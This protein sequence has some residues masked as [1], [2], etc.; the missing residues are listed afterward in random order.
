MTLVRIEPEVAMLE[1]PG[2]PLPHSLLN[3]RA[4]GGATSDPHLVGQ[5]V[6]KYI[7]PN[8]I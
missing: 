5:V 4:R 3:C 2:P 6:V 1:I 7:E 8:I